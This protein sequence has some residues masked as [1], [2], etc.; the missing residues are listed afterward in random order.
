M[1]IISTV[2]P[3]KYYDQQSTIDCFD[4]LLNGRWHTGLSGHQ[5]GQ[6]EMEELII[7]NLSISSN[8][9]VLDFGSGVGMVTCDIHHMTGCQIIGVNISQKQI[10]LSKQ[11]R[12]K[13]KIK[14]EFVDFFLIS[15]DLKKKQLPFPNNYFDKIIFFES[16]CHVKDKTQLFEELY[17]VLKPGGLLGGED[18]IVKDHRSLKE[19]LPI[20]QTYKIPSLLSLDNFSSLIES[21]HF[22]IVKMIDLRSHYNL[23]ASFMMDHF[24]KLSII[25]IIVYI[26]RYIFS[27]IL[28]RCKYPHLSIHYPRDKIATSSDININMYGQTL[29]NAYRKNIFSVGLIIIK[30]PA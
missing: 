30:K 29:D 28:I 14:K 26:I 21:A 10:A 9:K 15:G 22:S 18:W 23:D 24:E 27:Y 3:Q 8:D 16:V 2:D 7:K 12:S 13:L 19:I 25:G 6:I 5:L 17:R 20:C 4:N 11:L 1:E